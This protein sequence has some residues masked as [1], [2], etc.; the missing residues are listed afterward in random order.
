MTDIA[1]SVQDLSKRFEIYETPLSRIKQLIRAP[2]GKISSTFEKQYY[3]EFWALKDISF[4]IPK[5]ESFGIIGRNGAGKSTLLS[6]IA[7]TMAPTTGSIDVKGKVAALLELGSGFNPAF[8]GIENVYLNGSILGFSKKEIDEKLDEILAFADI[9]PFVNQLVKTY[10][11]GMTMRLAFAVQA[12]LEPEVLIVDE[13]LGV[14]DVFFQVKCHS[15][16]EKLQENGTSILFVTHSMGVI[17][18]YCKNALLL[19]EGRVMFKGESSE[20]IGMYYNLDSIM[21]VGDDS[22]LESRSV[23]REKMPHPEDWP[24]ENQF[25]SIDNLQVRLGSESMA[26]CTKFGIFDYRKLASKAFTW[27]DNLYLY[28]EFAITED[29]EI[30]YIGVSFLDARNIMIYGKTS[31]MHEGNDLLVSKSGSTVRV[32]M[33]IPLDLPAG[34]YV[35]TIGIN[36]M[37]ENTYK[38]LDKINF[39]DLTSN[40][41]SIVTYNATSF[42][43]SFPAKRIQPFF[44]FC[45]L[46]S[47]MYLEQL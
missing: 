8:T 35:C 47:K 39:Q 16:M 41:K 6:I 21:K 45:N 36:S 38:Y 42:N 13:A 26:H 11:S 30:P 12:C 5:G 32:R 28:A 40:T 37:N 33:E 23:L 46:S 19:N 14:G 10:S 17:E 4:E 3:K 24:D 31:F 25:P 7:G 1:I 22:G 2:L 43:V 18:K 9:G 29:I 34:D 27:K 20:A 44:G 15:R